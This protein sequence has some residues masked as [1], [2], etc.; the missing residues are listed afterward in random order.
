MLDLQTGQESNTVSFE[1]NHKNACIDFLVY[2]W[3]RM[4]PDRWWHHG[5]EI[6]VTSNQNT[7][8]EIAYDESVNK[9]NVSGATDICN[10][11][12]AT[13]TSTCNIVFHFKGER[14]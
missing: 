2:D 1:K 14:Y 8:G 12:C 11:V 6:K 13:G 10:R 9:L 3:N 7:I 4:V 5:S